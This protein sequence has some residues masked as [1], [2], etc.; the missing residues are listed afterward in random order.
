MKLVKLIDCPDPAIAYRAAA[1][2]LA[3]TVG[4]PLPMNAHQMNDNPQKGMVTNMLFDAA[5]RIRA[6]KEEERALVL[7]R[8]ERLKVDPD[9][10]PD[11]DLTENGEDDE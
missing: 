7:E 4:R 8:I 9:Y 6:A 2:V 11:S 1:G 3:Y 5:E 10:L